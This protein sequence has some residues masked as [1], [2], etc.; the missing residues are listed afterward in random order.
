MTRCARLPGR[1]RELPVG[2]LSITRIVELLRR[3]EKHGKPMHV[4]YVS[5]H[6]PAGQ[7][8]PRQV[9]RQMQFWLERLGIEQEVTLHPIALTAE[10]I[11]AYDLPT[12]PDSAL[13]MPCAARS[14]IPHT[15]RVPGANPIEEMTVLVFSFKRR[16]LSTF[17]Y[18]L[19]A[20]TARFR[21]P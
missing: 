15:Y 9:A 2:H 14:G 6:D 20:R 10:Q 11:R 3:A 16:A 4:L 8:M 1:G 21:R 12:A 7:N 17:S 5:D 19:G 13:T 18:D